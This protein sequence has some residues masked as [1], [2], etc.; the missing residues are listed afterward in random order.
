MAPDWS[1]ENDY[2]HL[3][4]T[5]LE[6]FGKIIDRSTPNEVC[7]F[8][9]KLCEHIVERGLPKSRDEDVCD[10]VIKFFTTVVSIRAFN[11]KTT[12]FWTKMINDGL[13]TD[14][15]AISMMKKCEE[16]VKLFYSKL[17]SL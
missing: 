11:L 6:S 2:N 17:D 9:Q 4:V 14:I 15:V 5:T 1:V 7:A 8:A 13:N 16:S 12:E 10:A 3:Y